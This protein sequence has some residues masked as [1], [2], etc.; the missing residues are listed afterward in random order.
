MIRV[1]APAYN[2]AANIRP[3][4]DAVN[5]ALTLMG[6]PF[7]AIVVDDGSTDAT[8]DVAA[9]MA[10]E[11]PV[12]L[13]RHGENRGLGLA[14]QTGLITALDRA[15]ADD[16]IVTMD[17][18]NSHPAE[19]IEAM[20]RKLTEGFDVVIASR[21]RS[22]AR[23]FGV[24]LHRRLLSVG[25]AALLSLAFPIRGVRDYTCGFRA[26]RARALFALRAD[27]GLDLANRRGFECMVYL[28]LRLRRLRMRFSEVPL[29][30]R[31]DRKQGES[32]M[33]IGR[34]ILATLKMI[35]LMKAGR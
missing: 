14:I 15:A 35:V 32:K 5:A 2:E 13:V 26:Y 27:K 17:A 18:D 22:G 29:V 9:T 30:L 12:V 28:L 19:L 33:R 6:R 23:T 16:T 21:F 31:Y 1:V 11:M 3:L 34:T 8:A 10:A 20:D 7:E 24:P 25:A 4:L